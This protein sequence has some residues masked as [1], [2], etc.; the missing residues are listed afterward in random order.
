[1]SVLHIDAHG[2]LNVP[3]HSALHDL[4]RGWLWN[5]T[6]RQAIADSADLAN[7]Q[8]I[9]AW[10][11]L[12][13]RVIW[14]RQG[15]GPVEHSTLALEYDRT[16]GAFI[17]RLEGIDID[18]EVVDV[19]PQT[20]RLHMHEVPEAN[21]LDSSRMCSDQSEELLMHLRARPYILDIDLDFF[22][23]DEAA[24][25]R[26]PWLTSGLDC[27]RHGRRWP[28][29]DCPLWEDMEAEMMSTSVLFSDKGCASAALRAWRLL[30]AEQK[31][32]LEGLHVPERLLVAGQLSTM[33]R[34]R[35]VDA[36]HMQRQLTRLD[37]FLG[38]LRSSPPALVTVARSADAFTGIFDVP[39]LESTVFEL[40]R[41]HW[42]GQETPS[43]G[44]CA[45]YAP[46]TAA[47]ES[48]PLEEHFYA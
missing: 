48:L 40:L 8:Q 17:E 3:E 11:G 37:V 26:P 38:Q 19:A 34:P 45:E 15:W 1:M 18:T 4:H 9:A 25:D 36:V 28:E 2:D 30:S 44:H 39:T 7:F 5:A 6:Q 27:P 22:V 23:Q 33:K 43:S 12:V 31:A 42:G 16:K 46:G 10:A 21:L 35:R 47:L 24:P 32:R 14:I 20:A 29:L 13:D 41:K